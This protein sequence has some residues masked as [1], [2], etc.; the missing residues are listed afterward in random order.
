MSKDG[1]LLAAG[2]L[3]AVAA[4]SAGI[5]VWYSS[6]ESQRSRA[7]SQLHVEPIA[8]VVARANAAGDAGLVAI[9]GA[10]QLEAPSETG[11]LVPGVTSPVVRS[12]ETHY[13]VTHVVRDG[14]IV[15][16]DV[17]VGSGQHEKPWVISDASGAAARPDSSLG[18]PP[19][20]KAPVQFE[21]VEDA[22]G[23]RLRLSA[24]GGQLSL[25]LEEVAPSAVVVGL[26]HR[27]RVLTA[28]TLLTI[29][30]RA[31]L[32]GSGKGLLLVAGGPGEPFGLSTDSL[33]TMV[34]RAASHAQAARLVSQILAGVAGA[35]AA[36]VLYRYLC[37]KGLLPTWLPGA[38][39]GSTSED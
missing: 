1:G 23:L 16:R 7:L 28:G 26:E 18:S 30:G 20:T 29:V 39:T 36:Y 13:A 17:Y 21:R 38:G 15:R 33:A 14:G 24:R 2:V 6:S 25:S 27:P 12:E 9:R 11:I 4:A 34:V 31:T 22:S 35:A 10:V 32:D 5:A 37:R 8:H 3:A 19:L